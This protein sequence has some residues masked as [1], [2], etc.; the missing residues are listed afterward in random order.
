MF[1]LFKVNLA[2]GTTSKNPMVFYLTYPSCKEL[3]ASI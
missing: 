3:V 1:P 2:D